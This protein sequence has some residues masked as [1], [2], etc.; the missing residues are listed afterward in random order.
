M[1]SS[2]T[3]AVIVG[4]GFAGVACAKQLQDHPGVRV[5]L[6]D[7][8]NH[9]VFQPLLY[10]VATATLSPG[11]V[12]APIRWIL[13]NIRNVKVLLANATRICGAKFG[14][15]FYYQDG[16][17]RPVAE[18]NVPT[19]FSDRV[20]IARTEPSANSAWNTLR[21]PGAVIF[22]SAFFGSNG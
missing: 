19:A 1:N 8:R 14:V 3:H 11:D 10:Q 2:E 6:I 20:L 4:G 18:L 22:G 15:M 13:R 21:P 12:A 9:H 5:T 17:L 16:A 7:R